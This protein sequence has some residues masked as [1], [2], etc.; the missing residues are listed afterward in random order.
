MNTGEKN[1]LYKLQIDDS[2]PFQSPNTTLPSKPWE[3]YKWLIFTPTKQSYGLFNPM[4]KR[5][6]VKRENKYVNGIYKNKSWK[7]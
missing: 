7:N 3:K 6:V 2:T 5:G 1:D 4:Y